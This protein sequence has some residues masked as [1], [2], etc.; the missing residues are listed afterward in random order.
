GVR[1]E[2]ARA[3]RVPR[4]RAAARRRAHRGRARGAGR[5]RARAPRAGRRRGRAGRGPR[6][7][8]RQRRAPC[9]ARSGRARAGAGALLRCAAGRGARNPLRAPPRGM[10]VS[11]LAFDLSDN[12]TG[13][14]DLLARLLAPRYEV[15][16]VGPRFGDAVWRPARDG[17]VRHR[18][19]PGARWP[20]FDALTVASRFLADRF[21]GILVPH[22]RDTEAW[23]PERFDRAAAR[24]RLGVGDARVVMFLGTPR[25]HKGV[26][27]LVE[28]TA[29]LDAARLV[30]VGAN[31][32]SAAARRWAAR[33]HVKVVGEIPFDDVPRYL[34]A[35]DVVAVPQRATTD[36]LGQVPAK[37]FDA[38]ALG[39]P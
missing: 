38:M 8:A 30:L 14:A 15:E 11:V 34:V 19:L 13:R 26:E 22:V 37:L 31:A 29:G 27:D 18:A 25:G 16:V 39:R 10:K 33:G 24:A 32:D 35:A 17:A 21:G 1:R 12:A 28:A 23:A 4:G 20:R 9:A 5:R 36:T 3:V 2:V 7:P 6:A